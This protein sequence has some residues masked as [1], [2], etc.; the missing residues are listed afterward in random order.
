MRFIVA[1]IERYSFCRGFCLAFV[2][3]LSAIFGLPA[4]RFIL[5][6]Y[7]YFFLVLD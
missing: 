2:R 4:T 6:A 3:Y 1:V 5:S 7:T